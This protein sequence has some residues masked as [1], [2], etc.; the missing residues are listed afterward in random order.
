MFYRLSTDGTRVDAA[1]EG[2]FGG[3]GRTSCWLIGGG[4]TLN[5]GVAAQ[6]V[7]TPVPRMCINLAGT[8]LFRPNLWTSYDPSARF[9]RSVYLDP[10]IMKFVHR[11]RAM[12]L[13]P[14]T[15]FKVCDCPQVYFFDR[16]GE[17]GFANFLSAD[18]RGIVDWADSMVQGIDLLFHLGIRRIFLAGCEMRVR[19]TEMQI[20]IARE[21][22]IEYAENEL[23]SEFLKRCRKAGVTE[24]SLDATGETDV[25]HFAERK[26]IRAAANTDFH[27]F[28]VS[29]YLRLSRRAMALAGVDLISVT[30]GSRLNDYFPFQTVESVCAEMLLEVGDPAHED[31]EGRYRLTGPRVMDGLGPMRD[32]KPHRWGEE[33]TKPVP[34]KREMIVERKEGRGAKGLQRL[35]EELEII[36]GNELVV[37]EEG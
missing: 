20:A 30:P 24:E 35:R 17:R 27:Y 14:E 29:Q 2:T 7:G 10:G 19:P 34:A 31:V 1:L 23:L 5:A 37:N 13:V 18:Q 15:T 33:K 22:G 11:R 25:Y 3:P 32:F 21:K 36:D 16:D 26:P 12:D 8:G 9:H 6:I 28:R 4:V